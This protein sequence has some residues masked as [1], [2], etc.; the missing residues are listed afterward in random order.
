MWL[1]TVLVLII[2]MKY[3]LP[4]FYLVSVSVNQNNTGLQYCRIAGVL[5]P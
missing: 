1:T 2:K 4:K 3:A 5:H